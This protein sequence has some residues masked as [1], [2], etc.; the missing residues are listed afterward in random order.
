M[1][2]NQVFSDINQILNQ[3]FEEKKAL[4]AVHRGTHAGNIVENTIPAFET[5]L[6]MGGDLFEFDLIRSTDGAIYA[7][8][9]GMEPRNLGCTENIKTMSSAQIDRLHYRNADWEIS[10][11]HVEKF[12][13]ILEHFTGNEL[14]NIDRAWDILPQITNLL[15]KYP[16]TIRQAIIKAPVRKELLA[17]FS[18]C[19]EKYMFMPVVRNMEE[20]HTALSCPNINLV[21]MEVIA[22]TSGDELYQQENLDFILE[23]G[24]FVWA[25]AITL[26]GLEES[27]LFGNL[28]DDL[29]LLEGYGLSWGEALRKGVRI[30]QTDWPMQLCQFRDSYFHLNPTNRL[31]Q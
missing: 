28:N 30:L 5:A 21:G 27:K 8:H 18:A 6:Q 17:F 1:F 20:V 22:K 15:K 10:G 13:N 23:H 11:V 31:P 29:A 9:D 25:N 12:E 3:R 26:S 7:F 19:P 24:L 4:I 16:N 14:Y 2:G